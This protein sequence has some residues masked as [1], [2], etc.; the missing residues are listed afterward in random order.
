MN[1]FLSFMKHI[2]SFTAQEVF[3]CRILLPMGIPESNS[4]IMAYGTSRFYQFL[5]LF[6][7]RKIRIFRQGIFIIS[8]NPH[9]NPLVAA[10]QFLIIRNHSHI[11][12][13][14]PEQADIILVRI[15]RH[16]KI[17]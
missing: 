2:L 6:R 10:V 12:V 7:I 5:Q 8:F 11:P 16:L 4:I 15:Q 3:L 17:R 9:I 13:L 1:Q 14:H